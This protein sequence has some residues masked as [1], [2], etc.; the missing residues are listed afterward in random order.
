MNPADKREK[1]LRLPRGMARTIFHLHEWIQNSRQKSQSSSIHMDWRT[2]S[3]SDYSSKVSKC[4]IMKLRNLY[5][6]VCEIHCDTGTFKSHVRLYTTDQ[7]IKFTNSLVQKING[8][9]KRAWN[10]KQEIGNYFSPE[11]QL[12]S[13]NDIHLFNNRVQSWNHLHSYKDEFRVTKPK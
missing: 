2:D 1:W 9:D 5:A 7:C 12:E 8:T 6:Q 13:F 4:W 11:T 10:S 3:K